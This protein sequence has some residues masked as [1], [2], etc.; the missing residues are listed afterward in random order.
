MMYYV[1]AGHL[2]EAVFYRGCISLKR[3]SDEAVFSLE[4]L[5][6]LSKDHSVI[7]VLC[8]LLYRHGGGICEALGYFLC[9][10]DRGRKDGGMID[11]DRRSMALVVDV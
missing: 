1:L 7:A 3:Y 5:H 2:F 11:H 4:L 9:E 6:T 10:H 8:S